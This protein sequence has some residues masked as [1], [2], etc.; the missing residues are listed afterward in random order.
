MILSFGNPASRVV[1]KD[2]SVQINKVLP[3]V[4][5]LFTSLGGGTVNWGQME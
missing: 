4:V 2:P 3:L 5:R 1:W